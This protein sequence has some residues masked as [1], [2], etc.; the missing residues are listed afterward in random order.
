[1]SAAWTPASYFTRIN[2]RIDFFG[3]DEQRPQLKKSETYVSVPV[4]LSIETVGGPVGLFL[5]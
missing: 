5:Q 1:M 2:V 3:L 4:D